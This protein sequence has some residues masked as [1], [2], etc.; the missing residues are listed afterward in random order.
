LDNCNGKFDSLGNYGYYATPTFPYLIG[1]DGPGIYN[2][3]EHFISLESMPNTLSR[4]SFNSC[5]RGQYPSIDIA[6]NGCIKCDAGKYSTATYAR[7]DVGGDGGG[8]LT[9]EIVCNM[10]CPVGYYCPAG[11]IKP[12]KCPAGR[13]GS[14]KNL[15]SSACE[16]ECYEGN[17]L[18]TF[19]PPYPL[20]CLS[21]LMFYHFRITP[22]LPLQATFVL[23]QACYP[24][25]L[26]AETRRTSALQ[27]LL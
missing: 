13:F 9:N 10:D 24:T 23:P 19:L 8:K 6:S 26:F 3:H 20:S 17:F 16:G 27:A 12:L 7:E 21:F 14:K 15:G 2:A 5:P 25:F 4:I 1:C 18:S 22:F 11:S